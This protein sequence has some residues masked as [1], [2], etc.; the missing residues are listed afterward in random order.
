MSPWRSACHRI[1]CAAEGTTV[2]GVDRNGARR[3]PRDFTV[4]HGLGEILRADLPRARRPPMSSVRAEAATP[5]SRIFMRAAP[6]SGVVLQEVPNE[7]FGWPLAQVGRRA[8]LD[9]RPIAQQHQARRKV[10]GFRNVMRNH[11]HRYC[12][13]RRRYAGVHPGVRSARSGP[14]NRAARRAA[15]ACGSSINARH[16]RNALALAARELGRIA[17]ASTDAGNCTRFASSAARC[18]MRRRGQPR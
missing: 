18:S 10:R 15:G 6:A 3:H 1:P 5:A 4:D 9:H 11:D 14:A 7:R 17:V 8:V 16:Q 12:R 2:H 13:V